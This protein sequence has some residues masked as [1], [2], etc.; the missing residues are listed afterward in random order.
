MAKRSRTLSLPFSEMRG[1][2]GI[3][4]RKRSDVIDERDFPTGS[5]DAENSEML[6][7][8]RVF[9]GKKQLTLLLRRSEMSPF[10]CDAFR[11]A[12]TAWRLLCVAGAE[13]NNN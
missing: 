5:L 3:V 13:Q 4:V 9:S 12:D 1:P 6:D 2:L 8:P 7:R 11:E 10:R